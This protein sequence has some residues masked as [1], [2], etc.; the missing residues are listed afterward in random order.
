MAFRRN[1]VVVQFVE[2]TADWIDFTHYAVNDAETGGNRIGIGAVQDNQDPPESGGDVEFAIGE[3]E[4]EITHGTSGNVLLLRGAYKA[5]EGITDEV[6]YISGH[7]GTPTDGN[8]QSGAGYARASIAVNGWS[9]FS[10]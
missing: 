3:L 9:N 7:N 1:N 4:L 8:E 5:L 10:S 6:L 2:P